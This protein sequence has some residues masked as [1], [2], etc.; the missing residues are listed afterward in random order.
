MMLKIYKDVGRLGG[1]QREW[2]SPREQRFACFLAIRLFL[3]ARFSGRMET[4]MLSSVSDALLH[5]TL[6]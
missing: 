6:A 2:G 5:C 1:G 3:Q 4:L